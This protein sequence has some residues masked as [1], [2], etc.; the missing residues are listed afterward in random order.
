MKFKEN[1]NNKQIKFKE[2]NMWTKKLKRFSMHKKK[3]EMC[4]LLV[5][6]LNSKRRNKYLNQK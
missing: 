5:V 6:Q 2:Q 4:Y 3:L 1:F